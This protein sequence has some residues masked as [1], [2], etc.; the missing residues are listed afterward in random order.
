MKHSK[1]LSRLSS[2]LCVLLLCAAVSVSAFAGIDKKYYKTIADKVWNEFNPVFLPSTYI[3]DSIAA[4]NSAVII[5]WS[6]DI[7]VDHLVKNTSFTASGMKNQLKKTHLQHVMIKLLDQSAIDRYNNFEFGK[8]EE[9]KINRSLLVYQLNGAFGA[10]VHKPDGRVIEVNL[11]DAI[12]VADKKTSKDERYYKI[13]IPGLEVGDVLEFFNFQD[14]VAESFNLSPDNILLGAKYPV[15]NRRLSIVS[16]PDMTVE[17][18]CYNGVPNLTRGKNEKGR[19]TA[20]LELSNIPG[21]NFSRFLEE[22]RQLPFVRIQFLNNVGKTYLASHARSGGLFGNIHSGKIISELGNYLSAVDYDGP[23]TGRAVK[24]VKDYFLASHP[25]ATPA[26]IADAAWLAMN[27]QNRIAKNEDDVISSSFYRAIAFVD[28]LRKLKVYAD[29]DLGIGIINPRS[30]VPTH[31]ISAWNESNFVVKTPDALYFMPSH[32]AIAPGEL[33][34]EYK[35]EKAA[36][37]PGDRK[38]IDNHTIIADYVVPAKRF[39]ENSMVVKDTVTITDNDMV[40]IDSSIKLT[41]GI[42]SMFSSIIEP[43][44]WTAEVEE[45]FGIPEAKRY[46]NK[47]FDPENRPAELRKELKSMGNVFYAHCPDSVTFASVLARGIRPD[48]KDMIIRSRNEFDG[49][50]QRLGDDI[51]LNVGMLTGMPEPLTENERQRVLDVMLPFIAQET[52]TLLVKAPEGYVFDEK[53]VSDLAR[54]VNDPAIQFVVDPRIT[55]DGELLLTSVIRYKL[56]DVPLAHWPKMMKVLDDAAA[57]ADAS[58]I[59]VPAK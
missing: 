51:S 42:K 7:D 17:Y 59:L 6:D 34:G 57:F 48:S 39:S 12:E 8:Q 9:V 26:E 30:D 46:K 11:D 28:I 21:V 31:D 4:G 25:E 5:A 58:V 16:H 54:H 53:S 40:V 47:E 29:E 15:L 18:K 49:L 38:K 13:A 37:F 50:V 52:H 23:I 55:D 10:R 43:A 14:E 44:E 33:P 45:Y 24:T 3:P 1:T 20:D 22:Y 2:L 32:L 19:Y 41:G 35:G 27:Y 56:A 36:I